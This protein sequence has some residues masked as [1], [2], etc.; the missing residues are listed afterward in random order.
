MKISENRRGFTLIEMLVTVAI[1]AVLLSILVPA[2]NRARIS[3]VRAASRGNLRELHRLMLEYAEDHGGRTVRKDQ[4]DVGNWILELYR[5]GYF[6]Y[7]ENGALENW[8]TR[9]KNEMLFSP[10][11]VMA[12]KDSFNPPGTHKTFAMNYNCQGV[13][14]ISIATPAETVMFCP[15]KWVESL[16]TWT[17]VSMGK[18]ALFNNPDCFN[19]PWPAAQDDPAATMDYIAVD[20]HVGTIARRDIP[21][22]TNER[23]WLPR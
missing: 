6:Q 13:N 10:L 8:N 2:T 16:G 12:H 22:N 4:W 3:A 17:A 21:E 20:G 7:T 14:I 9:D 18:N 5:Q 1:I 19:P 11:G 15:S 23:F